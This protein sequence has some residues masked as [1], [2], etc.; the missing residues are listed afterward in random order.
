M[1][2]HPNRE[3]AVGLIKNAVKAG[4]RVHKACQ[5]MAI[6]ERTY[7]RWDQGDQVKCDGR[8]T[9]KR[10]PPSNALSDEER[11]RIIEVCH[12]ERYKHLPPAK[13]I[14]LLAEKGIYLGSESTFYRI[15]RATKQLRR[16]GKAILSR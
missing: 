3:V 10:S 1:I 5:E 14:A 2:P 6:S 8:P 9:S 12:E 16:S 15:L 11:A 13:I 4:A 7:Y